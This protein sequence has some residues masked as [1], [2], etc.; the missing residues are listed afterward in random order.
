MP[1]PLSAFNTKNV[2]FYPNSPDQYPYLAAKVVVV[3]A[4]WA[5]LETKMGW[6]FSQLLGTEEEKGIAIYNAVSNM[7]AHTVEQVFRAVTAIALSQPQQDFAHALRII[8]SRVRDQRNPLAHGFWGLSP[9]IPDALLLRSPRESLKMS[10]V[11]V[12]KVATLRDEALKTG[13]LIPRDWEL[14]A[15][16]FG[17]VFVYREQDFLTLHERIIKVDSYWGDFESCFIP[18][19]LPPSAGEAEAAR[20]RLFGPGEVLDRVNRLRAERSEPPLI[21]L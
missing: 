7:G 18:G 17:E 21:P 19:K 12:R 6:I 10:G 9:D 11:L 3:L 13:K 4:A 2:T 16:D 5:H 8:T 15:A 14:A 20:R 1:Q